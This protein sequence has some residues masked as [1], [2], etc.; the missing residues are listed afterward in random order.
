MSSHK[1][2]EENIAFMG[3]D[4][5]NGIREILLSSVTA[6]TWS[7]TEIPEKAVIPPAMIMAA[8]PLMSLQAIQPALTSKIPE[9]TAVTSDE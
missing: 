9:K 3:R 2:A 4:K 6:A 1:I 8:L 7:I 5:I